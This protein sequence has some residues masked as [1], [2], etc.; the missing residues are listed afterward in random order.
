M[1]QITLIAIAAI[2]AAAT[3]TSCK[4]SEANYR[5]AYDTT[6][7]RQ[8]EKEG[9]DK[10]PQGKEKDLL[11]NEK[12]LKDTIA[13]L[14]RQMRKAAEDL[15]FEQA[16]KIRDEIRR[17]ENSALSLSGA[18]RR[19]DSIC[20]SFGKADKRHALHIMNTFHHTRA[21]IVRGQ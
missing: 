20:N 11:V 17:L 10:L 21:D 18:W 5:A 13:K 2:A 16:A 15:E 12:K 1:K 6:I 4:S 8:R 19:A 7:Q 14:T 3:F 9:V